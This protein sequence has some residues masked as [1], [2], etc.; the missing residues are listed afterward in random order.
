MPRILIVDDSHIV[1]NL[2]SFIFEKAGFDCAVAENGFLALEI[3]NQEDFDLVVTDINMPRMDG[4]ELTRQI[5]KIPGKE[6]IPIIIVSTEE[7]A[8]D[9]MKGAEAGANVYIT[10]PAEPEAL[11]EN[12]KMLLGVTAS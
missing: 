3:L 12:S 8:E 1:L 10:K 11:I 4:Y 2:H 7:E 6:T 5:R 9:K